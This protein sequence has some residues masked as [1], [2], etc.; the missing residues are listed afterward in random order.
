MEYLNYL[1][2]FFV[3]PL[4]ST[5][6]NCLYNYNKVYYVN[7]L[8]VSCLQRITENFCF[9]K[10][11]IKLIRLLFIDIKLLLLNIIKSR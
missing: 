6:L 7:K 11:K 2:L 1:L 10:E 8:I 9:V 4:M 3:Q 5:I